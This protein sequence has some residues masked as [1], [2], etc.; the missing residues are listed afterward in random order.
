MHPAGQAQDQP[1]LRVQIGRCPLDDPTMSIHP[2]LAS[3]G[4]TERPCL[5]DQLLATIPFQR[6]P[7]SPKGA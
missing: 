3:Q 1:A 5:T 6:V 7:D 4:G 2:H